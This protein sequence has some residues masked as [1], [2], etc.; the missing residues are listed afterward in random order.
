M[1][2]KNWGNKT[3]KITIGKCYMGKNGECDMGKLCDNLTKNG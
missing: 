2:N 1:G 3:G